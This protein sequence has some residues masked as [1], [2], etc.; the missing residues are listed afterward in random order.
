MRIKF[1]NTLSEVVAGNG[2][3]LVAVKDNSSSFLQYVV[4]VGLGINNHKKVIA[5]QEYDALMLIEVNG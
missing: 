1:L 3:K 5:K 4:K 2:F